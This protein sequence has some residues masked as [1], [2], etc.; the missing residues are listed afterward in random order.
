LVV[1]FF[2]KSGEAGTII[3]VYNFSIFGISYW[4]IFYT[5]FFVEWNNIIYCFPLLVSIVKCTVL[6]TIVKCFNWVDLRYIVYSK[7]S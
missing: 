1:F 4:V 6:L 3:L 2:F 5:F 7:D